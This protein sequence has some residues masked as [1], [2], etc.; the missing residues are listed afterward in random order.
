[1]QRKIPAEM[2]I[3]WQ[4]VKHCHSNTNHEQVCRLENHSSRFSRKKYRWKNEVRSPIGVFFWTPAVVFSCAVSRG[5]ASDQPRV[6][7]HPE[8]LN[9]LILISRTVCRA[10]PTYIPSFLACPARYIF[11]E[12]VDKVQKKCI[13]SYLSSDAFYKYM[14]I[15][16]G[17]LSA[18]KSALFALSF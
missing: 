6:P 2:L 3:F 9:H 14:L 7:A 17:T 18:I 8:P 4:N 1:M 10:Y 12:V 16:R 15:N 11:G 5:S 13:S